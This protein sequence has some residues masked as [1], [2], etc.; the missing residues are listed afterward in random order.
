MTDDRSLWECR[1][2]RTTGDDCDAAPVWQVNVNGQPTTLAVDLD[3]PVRSI[4]TPAILATG[5]ERWGGEDRWE[6]RDSKGELFDESFSF[7]R[8]LDLG[9]FHD[10]KVWI[11]LKPGVGA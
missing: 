1:Q 10:H 11:G 3:A 4:K 9:R 8:L 5:N 2:E 7:R 6:I